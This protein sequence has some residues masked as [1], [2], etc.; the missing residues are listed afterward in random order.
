MSDCSAFVLVRNNQV[1][2][3]KHGSG[4]GIVNFAHGAISAVMNGDR[5]A[6]TFKTGRVAL[7]R[8]DAK[9]GTVSLI[10]NIS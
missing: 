10:G 3:R 6:V 9:R 8:V 5:V 4:G 2:L 7:Y 1:E